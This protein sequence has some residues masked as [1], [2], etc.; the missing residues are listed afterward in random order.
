MTGAAAVAAASMTFAVMVV[1]AVEI[2][3]DLQ[4]S[5]GKG[6]GNFPD[7]A[8]CAADDF[9]SGIT[10]GIDGS[11]ADTAA[12]QKINFFSGEQSCQCAVTGIAGGEFFLADDFAVF[13]FKE[14]KSGRMSEMLK[15]IMI[16]TSD[17]NFHFFTSSVS[18]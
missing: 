14:S 18:G 6:F 8:C 10:E 9:D 5:G 2:G 13:D 17:R 7:I 16:F 11:A 15:D 3:T 4:R 12:D 1:I